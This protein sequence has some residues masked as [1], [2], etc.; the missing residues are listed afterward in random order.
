MLFASF[1]REDPRLDT[2]DACLR[3]YGVARV[4]AD[5]GLTTDEFVA[6]VL[7]APSTR[8]DRYTILESLAMDEEEARARV[9]AFVERFAP[10]SQAPETHGISSAR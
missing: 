1:L 4:P 6:A 5:I 9:E 8:P 10:A 3:R 7:K 2:F